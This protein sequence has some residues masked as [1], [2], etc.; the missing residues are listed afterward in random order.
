MAKKSKSS[1]FDIERQVTD[2][3]VH[4]VYGRWAEKEERQSIMF[5]LVHAFENFN[6]SPTDTYRKA[7]EKAVDGAK[8]FIAS[9]KGISEIED[10]DSVKRISFVR[11]SSYSSCGSGVIVRITGRGYANVNNGNGYDERTP[12]VQFAELDGGLPTFAKQFESVD[13]ISGKDGCLIECFNVFI[14]GERHYFTADNL[15]VSSEDGGGK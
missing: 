10:D 6:C 1:S 13:V 7:W 12:L 2:S 15:Y 5:A 8:A 9:H 4:E 3:L 14:G 11:N